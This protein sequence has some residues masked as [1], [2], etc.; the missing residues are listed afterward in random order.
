VPRAASLSARWGGQGIAP[1]APPS[2]PQFRKPGKGRPGYPPAMTTPAPGERAALR[3]RRR[4]ERVVDHIGRHLD[5]DLDLERLAAVA[6]FSPCHFHRIY[7]ATMGETVTETV[8]R[9]RLHRAAAELVEGLLPIP[10]IARRAGYSGVAA[11]TR[12]FSATYGI[13]PAA[14]RARG[15]LDAPP[16]AAPRGTPAMTDVTIRTTDPVRVAAI[17]HAGDYQEI[18]HAFER[19]QAW[20]GSGGLI[21]PDTRF[22]GIFHDD[23][24]SVA[25]DRLRADACMTV[26]PGT[27]PPDGVRML[28]IAGGRHA[29]L[30][31]R[32]PYA[33]LER[34]YRRLYRDWLPGSGEEPADRPCIEEYLNDC[35]V[36]PPAEWLTDVLMPLAER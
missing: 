28:E 33:E 27:V 12:A 30:R 2:R 26:P 13:P 9:R 20:A 3:H 7:R 10:R 15:P 4:I 25:K 29:V 23:P 19:L 6:C 24:T 22:F 18:G 32:G 5:Q 17:A 14:Y 35:R 16:V 11:F 8:R 36:L 31:H 34:T 1:A 21:G